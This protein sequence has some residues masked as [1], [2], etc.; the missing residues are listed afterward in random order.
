VVIPNTTNQLDSYIGEDLNSSKRGLYKLKY[1]LS[2]GVIDYWDDM[3]LLWK[4]AFS[5]LKIAPNECP[6]LLTEA[7]MNPT[8]HRKRMLEI[9][10]EKFQVPAVYV[11]VQGV[12]SL[13]KHH[14]IVSQQENLQ[15]SCWTLEMVLHMLYLSMKDILSLTLVNVWTLLVEMLLHIS[16]I[17]FAKV[18]LI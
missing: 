9:F 15:V 16:R 5:L 17:C 10:F 7:N 1:P 11:A 3:E 18:V 4:H 6:V 14:D 13:Y 8:K 12:L 2:H